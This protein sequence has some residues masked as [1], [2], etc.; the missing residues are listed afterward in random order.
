MGKPLV[1]LAGPIT[2]TEPLVNS[3]RDVCRRKFSPDIDTIDPLRQPFETVKESGNL[4]VDDRLR[5]SRHGKAIAS[6]D[7][8]DVGRCDI[9]LVN[10]L[11]ATE[12][13]IGSV[14]EIFWADAFRKPIIVVREP[15]NIHIHAMLDALVGWD[16]DDI[17]EAIKVARALL[18]IS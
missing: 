14:G 17:D 1:Y 15:N 6:R 12:I 2:G 9:L 18:G 10:L 16:L 7:R 13:S 3:W 11:G 8:F 4:T 5:L